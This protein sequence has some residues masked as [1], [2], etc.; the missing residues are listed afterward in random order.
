MAP[1]ERLA[2]AGLFVSLLSLAGLAAM[3]WGGDA[4]PGV[5]A[6]IVWGVLLP[7]FFIMAVAQV[8]APREEE[9]EILIRMKANTL[10]IGIFFLAGGALVG[11]SGFDPGAS[12]SAGVMMCLTFAVFCVYHGAIL[13]YY[14]RGL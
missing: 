8:R 5:T 10:A 6:P 1:R 14:R 3:T 2:L 9:R 4:V 11:M 12:I 7:S 13:Y